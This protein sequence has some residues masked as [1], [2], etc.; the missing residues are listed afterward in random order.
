MNFSDR[1]KRKLIRSTSDSQAEVNQEAEAAAVILEP[2]KN[3][4]NVSQNSTE[5]TLPNRT[6]REDAHSSS[7]V[8]LANNSANPDIVLNETANQRQEDM[9]DEENN[10]EN[11][12]GNQFGEKVVDSEKHCSVISPNN[13]L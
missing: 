8:L 7:D 9:P 11:D 5:S 10:I 1:E 3:D 12:E 4:Y 2:K 13:V 6:S